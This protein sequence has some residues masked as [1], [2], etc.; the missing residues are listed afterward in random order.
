MIK[1]G[2]LCLAVAPLMLFCL[3]FSN[4]PKL[5][6]RD[7]ELL[8]ELK[9]DNYSS[10][11][12]KAVQN[13]FFKE[14]DNV[15]DYNYRVVSTYSHCN[16]IVE[17]KV[18]NSKVDLVSSLSFVT[19]ANINRIHYANEYIDSA[20]I[21]ADDGV[22]YDSGNDGVIPDQNYSAK[23]MNVPTIANPGQGSFLA[24]LDSSF[25]LTHEGFTALNGMVKYSE[26]DMKS[27]VSSSGFLGAPDA[28]HSTYYNSKIPFYYDYGGDSS[29]I[30]PDYDVFSDLSYHGQHVATLCAGNGTYK[31]IAPYAQLALMK[32]FQTYM[33]GKNAKV[34]APDSAILDALEDCVILNVD[35]VNL[36]LGTD[37]N[38]FSLSPT[39]VSTVNKLKENGTNVN[40]A[41]GNTS[42]GEYQQSGLY[43]N[44]LTTNS[45]IGTIGN[46]ASLQ[47]A[48]I[49]ASGNIR[50]DASLASVISVGENNVPYRDQV[51]SHTG[52]DDSGNDTT[53]TFD[54]QLPFSSLLGLDEDYKDIE[55]V[56]VPN[57][58]EE[59]DYAS[60]DVNNKI[61]VV[62]R[63]SSTFV[64][65]VTQ[66][67]KHG[68]SAII[69]YNS[70]DQ[71]TLGW[72]ILDGVAKA[73]LI[74]VASIDNSL[75]SIFL[76]AKTKV[77]RIS[78]DYVSDF[79]SN[80]PL[81]SLAI[82][83]DI[84]TPGQNVY[85]GLTT[86]N[87]SYGYLSGTSMATPNYTG[88]IGLMVGLAN[89]TGEARKT[90]SNTLAMRTMSTAVPVTQSNGAF[91]SPS[92]VGAG[93][94]NVANA[95]NSS[96]Y[97]EGNVLG[98]TK[99]EL[100]NNAEIS[101]G[102]IKF[103]VNTHNEGTTSKT[104]KAKLYVEAPQVTTLDSV[105]YPAYSGKYFRTIYDKALENYAFD[106][107]IP[108]GE[109]S[110][111]VDYTI[112]DEAKNYLNTYFV[113]GTNLE[114][115]V[116][117]DGDID[118]SIPYLGYY[119][120]YDK[121]F[122]VEPYDFEREDGIVYGSDLVNSLCHDTGV[123]LPYANFNSAVYTTNTGLED[124][125]IADLFNNSVK[126]DS[127]F[128]KANAVNKDG[129]WYLYAGNNGFT[130]TLIF[131]QFVNR[132]VSTNTITMTNARGQTVLTD[133]MF[134]YL[135]GG[136]ENYGLYRSMASSSFITNKYVADRA[137]TII[138]LSS[139]SDGTY[140]MHFEYTLV[141]GSVQSRD[142]GLVIASTSP[143][144]GKVVSTSDSYKIKINENNVYNCK[145]GGKSYQVID[146]YV[147]I[148]TSGLSSSKFNIEVT[149]YA[150]ASV[151]AVI[152]G[153]NLGDNGFFVSKTDD[154]DLGGYKFTTSSNSDGVEF[155]V[156]LTDSYGN[157]YKFASKKVYQFAL[158][159]GNTST[160]GL[161]LYSI[162][163][164][165][166]KSKATYT[167]MDGMVYF[168][169]DNGKFIIKGAANLKASSGTENTTP[170][171]V[172]VGLII[173][174]AG[175]VVLVAGLTVALIFIFR[176]KKANK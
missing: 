95:I 143:S 24:I 127:L 27:M 78:K 10:E 9:D 104:Y 106:V 36:S 51:V 35:A 49:I 137:Y 153:K 37:F 116:V 25:L 42:K 119:G 115:Y 88:V 172:N 8:V 111:S 174:V 32:V 59:A 23:Q 176:K 47:N 166:N 147:T 100:K 108:V 126:P 52:K 91:Y 98:K 55:Y 46:L 146:G 60:I 71:G 5:E 26:A 92:K 58:G 99:I 158:Y 129:K 113:N 142:L 68:A 164:Y 85:G 70:A 40:I 89:K 110:F 84:M 154:T 159:I 162:D 80:G 65:K 81:S 15:L 67:S 168:T 56:V 160:D 103:D 144:L 123:S 109:N 76:D 148:P 135:Y 155:V 4:S 39:L 7:T 118:L 11:E 21:G 44:Y 161:T 61:A 50:E 133:H 12:R 130:N 97:L 124:T 86:S 13:T 22:L 156:S 79:S 66:A 138:P 94:I 54:P 29:T 121:E 30:T 122:C 151:Y 157:A 6:A 19:N 74:P 63:G 31:G 101:K 96:V 45:E 93:A 17:I 33:D 145:V 169:S 150:G 2:F 141:D 163:N 77:L 132:N 117:L 34:G 107:T 175:G 41:A 73:D 125:N 16:N 14:L 20:A 149:N 167:L 105:S 18:P 173:G 69:I 72:M 38:D 139:Y 128:G 170:S 64:D 114:G 1:K 83:P 48:N 90:Y 165:G 120:D 75:K 87:T 134:S 171:D 57:Y 152:D 43:S 62:A 3:S 131:T 82:G 140:N 136:E 112:S 53:T 102:E 28:T